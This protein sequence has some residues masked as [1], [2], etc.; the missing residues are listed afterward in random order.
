MGRRLV[1]ELGLEFKMSLDPANMRFVQ[2]L[3]GMSPPIEFLVQFKYFHHMHHTSYA[4]ILLRV[5]LASF[6]AP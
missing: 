3:K 1:F 2:D 5:L 6:Q 4:S